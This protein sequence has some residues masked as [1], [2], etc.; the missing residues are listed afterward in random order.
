MAELEALARII[1]DLNSRLPSSTLPSDSYDRTRVT[2]LAKH[3]NDSARGSFADV[4]AEID[5]RTV[6]RLE[7]RISGRSFLSEP[8][9]LLVFEFSRAFEPAATLE[10]G[11]SDRGW[12][13]QAVSMISEEVDK[14]VPR[15][16]VV[17]KLPVRI[18]VGVSLLMSVAFTVGQLLQLA[19][20]P[21]PWWILLN[22][23]AGVA[24]ALPLLVRDKGWIWLFPKVEI[25]TPGSDPTGS[26]RISFAAGL[27][28]TVT[29]GVLVNT[30]S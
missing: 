19:G 27:I 1:E 23:L 18:L 14:G 7:F 22:N 24:V 29:L 3:G 17:H 15:W 25:L 13:N 4:A 30:I 5:R 26:R 21:A 8:T 11:N 6:S 20:V 10:V 28:L 16:A 9:L 12:V 2:F